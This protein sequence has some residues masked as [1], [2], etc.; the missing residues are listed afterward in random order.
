MDNNIIDKNISNLREFS[1]SHHMMVRDRKAMDITGV[2]R[3]ES[4]NSEEF[5]LETVLGYM[6]I[7]GQDLEMKNFDM[8]KGEL[9]ISGYVTAIEYYDHNNEMTSTKGFISKFF[10]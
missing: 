8:E 2:K 7:S 4:L 6:T 5:I 3:I 10:K 1:S 9:L